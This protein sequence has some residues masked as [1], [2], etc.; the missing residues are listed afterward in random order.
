[1]SMLIYTIKSIKAV[2]G[3]QRVKF[4]EQLVETL[5]RIGEWRRLSQANLPPLIEEELAYLSAQMQQPY[6]ETTIKIEVVAQDL[7]H[8]EA[9]EN[10]IAE[11][12]EIS[13]RRLFPLLRR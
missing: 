9:K 2:G 4:L 3:R 12:I 10:D 7:K 11:V 1:M 13:S 6:K 5:K 8:L